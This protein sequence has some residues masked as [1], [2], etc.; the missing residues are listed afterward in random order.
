MDVEG[1]ELEVLKGCSRLLSRAPKLA[2]E[3][4][5]DDLRE[6][7]QTLTDIF[8]LIDIERYV[9]EMVLRPQDFITLHVF[10][11]FAIPEKGVINLFLERKS[12]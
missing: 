4:H 2:L 8:K 12:Q 10:N 7:G 9:G 3:L 5:I 11:R 1:Y 6:S